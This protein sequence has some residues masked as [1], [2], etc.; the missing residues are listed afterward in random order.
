[1][2]VDMPFLDAIERTVLSKCGRAK[3][4][5]RELRKVVQFAESPLVGRVRVRPASAVDVR[6]CAQHAMCTAPKGPNLHTLKERERRKKRFC[7]FHQCSAVFLGEIS[8]PRG[9]ASRHTALV[10][11]LLELWSF[12]DYFKKLFLKRVL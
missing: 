5:A 9:S 10:P 2:P 1:M 7:V 4:V 12:P 8:D 3:V 11:A 6:A